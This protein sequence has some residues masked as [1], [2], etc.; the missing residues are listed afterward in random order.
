[1]G[2][3]DTATTAMDA[4]TIARILKD[5]EALALKNEA[6]KHRILLEAQTRLKTYFQPVSYAE[7]TPS[8]VSAIVPAELFTAMD[9]VKVEPKWLESS[10]ISLTYKANTDAE[11]YIMLHHLPETAADLY[12]LGMSVAE[13]GRNYYG[14]Y[15][16]TS[17][18]GYQ[19]LNQEAAAIKNLTNAA[20]SEE[21]AVNQNLTQILANMSHQHAAHIAEIEA[22]F[23]R[24]MTI[25]TERTAM[26]FRKRYEQE[27]KAASDALYGRTVVV[28]QDFEIELVAIRKKLAANIQ[29]LE[30][31]AQQHATSVDA[32]QA[33][34]DDQL[35]EFRH[36]LLCDAEKA[37]MQFTFVYKARSNEEVSLLAC[38]YP[39]TPEDFYDLAMA[40]KKGEDS[41]NGGYF[42]VYYNGEP[43]D[44]EVL[45]WFSYNV[46]SDAA[47]A[48]HLLAKSELIEAT[49]KG[50]AEA[51]KHITLKEFHGI[52]GMSIK[53]P[54]KFSTADDL[55]KLGS[56]L[57]IQDRRN[58]W[59]DGK[60]LIGPYYELANGKYAGK[61][62]QS[63]LDFAKERRK[64][65]AEESAKRAYADQTTRVSDNRSAV[66]APR[67]GNEES[68]VSAPY[69]GVVARQMAKLSFKEEQEQVNS[70]IATTRSPVHSSAGEADSAPLHRS[71]SIVSPPGGL[72]TVEIDSPRPGRAM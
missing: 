57:I 23:Q 35:R 56:D 9:G 29:G 64:L 51:R 71:Q 21:A 41:L 36:N 31:Q 62:G 5:E 32:D 10:K 59:V 39:E 20:A 16:W 70:S 14:E 1:M 7:A 65:E 54:R 22:R 53:L 38:K 72:V 3:R 26:V 12:E 68:K 15:T 43:A 19:T 63:L 44:P 47:N 67:V 46:L 13:N 58:N 42:D 61:L 28:R 17:H 30:S 48:G 24:A 11:T 33:F 6:S 69:V 8:S 27:L 2:N 18:P 25:A 50:D 40:I 49:I 52:H 55:H 45:K 60:P 37:G 34:T 4:R 66:F